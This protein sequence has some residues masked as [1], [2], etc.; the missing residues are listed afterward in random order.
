[1]KHTIADKEFQ[2]VHAKSRQ[3]IELETKLGHPIAKLESNATYQAICQIYCM[4]ILAS[5][6]DPDVTEDWI[7]DNMEFADM[8]L[9]SE[10]VAY[11][12]A[13]NKN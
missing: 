10:V 13:V 2:I 12:L 1:M 4:A 7:L 11:F 8:N 9:H 3:I 6:N 5:N